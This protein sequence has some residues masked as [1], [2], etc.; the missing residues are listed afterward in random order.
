M[1]IVFDLGGVVVKWEP[2]ALIARLFAPALRQRVFEQVVAHDDWLELDRGTLALPLA[3]ARAADRTGLP[4]ASLAE[5]FRQVPLSLDLM[6]GT[7]ELLPRVK[8]AGHGLYCLSNMAQHSL[9]FL[10]RAYDFWPRFDG[11]VFSCVVNLIKPEPAI[12]DHLLRE[13]GLQATETVFIDDLQVNLDAAAAF[14]MKTIRFESA[15]QCE[16]ALAA[17]GCALGSPD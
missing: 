4:D 10:E 6:P 16:R 1:N 13:H 7:H 3:I 14:G 17:L 11:R 5:F 9:E 15:A 2:H 8:Q 12:Y